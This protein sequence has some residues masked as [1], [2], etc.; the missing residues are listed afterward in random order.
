MKKIV[1]LFLVMSLALSLAIIPAQAAAIVIEDSFSVEDDFTSATPCAVYV[2]SGYSSV[3]WAMTTGQAYNLTGNAGTFGT[4]DNPT[5]QMEVTELDEN[6]VMHVSYLTGHTGVASKAKTFSNVAYDT[7]YTLFDFMVPDDDTSGEFRITARS[8]TNAT[9]VPLIQVLNDTMTEYKS[10]GALSTTEGDSFTFTRGAWYKA[11][12]EATSTSAHI[13]I[14]DAN[15]VEKLNRKITGLTLTHSQL[16]MY[17]PSQ[18]RGYNVYL[19]NGKI[20]TAN[21]SSAAESDAGENLT[22]MPELQFTLDRPVLDE[23]KISCTVVDSNGGTLIANTDYTF[24]VEDLFTCKLQALDLF[25]KG[26]EYTVTVSY[27]GAPIRI[28]SFTTEENHLLSV[29]TMTVDKLN[30]DDTVSEEGIT[31]LSGGKIKLHLSVEDPLTYPKFSGIVM[32]ALYENGAM[33][34]VDFQEVDADIS[35]VAP[36]FTL[37]AV[38]PNTEMKVF[39]LDGNQNFIP[40][41]ESV[42]F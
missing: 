38:T 31:T 12:L 32:V 26:L 29:N 17:F 25:G 39:L 41:A 13:I 7:V 19:D 11:I 35:D 40:L 8:S 23:T 16:R 2:S 3:V 10:N 28:I 5:I 14:Y 20:V 33:K 22:R 18:T 21:S 42:L 30:A 1:T 27:D 37:P 15:G 4:E 34:W 24:T 36:T 9:S 6:P